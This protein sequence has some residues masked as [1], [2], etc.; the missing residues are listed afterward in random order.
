MTVACKH[1]RYSLLILS[2]T[3]GNFGEEHRLQEMNVEVAS[4]DGGRT[5]A[6]DLFHVFIETPENNIK[7]S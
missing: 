5:V 2:V 4:L 6:G 3:S 7:R 1:G